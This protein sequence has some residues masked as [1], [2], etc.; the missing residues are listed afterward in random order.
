MEGGLD[1]QRTLSIGSK[2]MIFEA[3]PQSGEPGERYYPDVGVMPT[4]QKGVYM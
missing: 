4:Y 1:L 3:L 2:V